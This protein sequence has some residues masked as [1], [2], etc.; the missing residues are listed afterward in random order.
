MCV[1]GPG[2]SG[3]ARSEQAS[4]LDLGHEVTWLRDADSGSPGGTVSHASH[5]PLPRGH[6]PLLAKA[7]APLVV[8]PVEKRPGDMSV[9][10]RA[11]GPYRVE[12]RR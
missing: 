7:R 11:I 8:Q 6:D 12:Q 5:E 2:A 10:A 1:E 9:L 3:R 4:H